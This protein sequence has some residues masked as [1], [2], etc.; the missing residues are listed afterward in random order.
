MQA[1]RVVSSVSGGEGSSHGGVQLWGG[2]QGPQESQ[3][4]HGYSRAA[5]PGSSGS[6]APGNKEGSVH[7]ARMFGG[8]NESST[9]S[10]RAS[11]GSG[12][13]RNARPPR[14]S[15]GGGLDGGP[16]SSLSPG[17]E[18]VKRE[19]VACVGVRGSREGGHKLVS[20][21]HDRVEMGIRSCPSTEINALASA[22]QAL[23]WTPERWTP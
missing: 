18:C 21:F 20:K 2:H 13:V 17:G 15:Y 19:R 16:L 8:S 5:E 14:L 9:H 6:T 11:G 7:G 4:P 23:R 22:L 3:H 12:S 1:L 10:V